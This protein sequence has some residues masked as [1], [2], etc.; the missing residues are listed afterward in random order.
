MSKHNIDLSQFDDSFKSE[1]PEGG[2]ISR[3]CPT[4][5][6]RWPSKRWS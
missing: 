1:Q 6:T 3:A 2:A 5:S 4:A